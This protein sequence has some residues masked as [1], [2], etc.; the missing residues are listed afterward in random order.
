LSLSIAIL[1]TD[2]MNRKIKSMNQHDNI[3]LNDPNTNVISTVSIGVG[4]DDG[5]NVQSNINITD[6][7]G[8]I[9]SLKMIYGIMFRSMIP[10]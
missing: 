7:Y 5:S 2:D 1:Q 10:K 3:Q 6:Y 8:I 4:V 9:S